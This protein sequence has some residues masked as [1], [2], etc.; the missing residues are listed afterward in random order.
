MSSYRALHLFPSA[1]KGRLSADDWIRH[2]S[3]SIAEC[4]NHIADVLV[5]TSSVWFYPRSLSYMVSGS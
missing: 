5:L 2:G 1:A 4:Q 3:M